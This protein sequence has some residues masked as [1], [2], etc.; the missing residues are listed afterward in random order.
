MVMRLT[1]ICLKIK[2][3]RASI[4]QRFYEIPSRTTQFGFVPL[5]GASNRAPVPGFSVDSI[6]QRSPGSI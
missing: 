4:R 5:A 3:H 1:H 6:L 2:Q